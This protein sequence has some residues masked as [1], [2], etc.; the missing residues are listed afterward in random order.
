MGR[1]RGSRAPDD[2]AELRLEDELRV[3]RVAAVR[4]IRPLLKLCGQE[5]APPDRLAEV[6]KAANLAVARLWMAA[7][8]AAERQRK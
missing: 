8:G 1:P 3:A 2:I 5:D 7:A 6:A 4:S